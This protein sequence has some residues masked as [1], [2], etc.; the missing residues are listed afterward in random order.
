M[1]RGSFPKGPSFVHPEKASAIGSRNSMHRQNRDE[2]EESRQVID[3]EV[4][5]ILRHVSAKLPP[6]VLEKLH[7][8]GNVKEI[9][10]NYYNQNFQ[11]MLNRYLVTVEDEMSKKF[12]NI[13]DEEEAQS[14]DSYQPRSVG[15]LIDHLGNEQQFTSAATDQSIVNIYGSLQG[16]IQQGTT[17]LEQATDKLLTE[18]RDIGAFVQGKNAYSI[19][20]CLFSD[21]PFKPE[22]VEDIDLVI[23][24]TEGELLEPI[25]HY[26]KAAESI[27]R[28]ILSARI[29]G[30]I[31]QEVQ[32]LDSKLSAEGQG[33]DESE[34]IF[35]QLKRL[36]S[37][38]EGDDESIAQARKTV[39]D[40]LKT[41]SGLS[42]EVDVD[43]Y[44]S[45][46]IR[47]NV[48]KIM[49]D[50]K[51]RTQGFN[52]AVTAMTS[53]LDSSRLGYQH[54]ETFK[55]S[56]Q[57]VIREYEDTN[58]HVLPDERY[59]ITLS[60]YDDLQL[61]EMRTA[62]CQQLDEFE[63]EAQKLWQV[64]E[65]VYQGLKET[66]GFSDYDSVTENHLGTKGRGHGEV[67]NTEKLWDEI[68]F[69]QPEKSSQEKLNETFA[70]KRRYLTNKFKILRTKIQDLFVMEYPEHRIILDQR[71]DFLE[72]EFR[73]FNRSH[74]PFHV[75]PGLLVKAT[76]STIK[77]QE[78]TM[79]GMSNVLNE[80]L[81]RISSGFKDTAIEEHHRQTIN[82]EQ[83]KSFSGSPEEV[84]V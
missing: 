52:Q 23:N 68:S 48:Q 72:E 60:Y 69:I 40:F 80:F 15:K 64:F 13:V 7:V 70:E 81:N 42:S 14:L 46:N 19:V 62:Y 58:Y 59:S 34:K 3:E 36:E 82:L 35:E 1:A 4:D 37:Y 45:L 83:V 9:L 17:E 53:I 11:N 71:L 76:I 29:I 51:L 78:V 24:I 41:I 67:G 28:D 54:I 8:G 22:T 39:E 66:E 75:Q 57:V 16:Q 31:D 65:R 47:E 84:T 26:Q 56:R 61:R 63:S 32:E 2:N 12:H 30:R 6:E 18:R 20:K 49:E 79:N 27:I 43:E 77:R 25:F 38:M 74:N 55:N 50:E 73:Q 21:N 44:D 33:L 10:H 5:K